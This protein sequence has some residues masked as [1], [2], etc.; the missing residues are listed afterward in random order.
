MGFITILINECHL[1]K[2]TSVIKV[3]HNIINSITKKS[4]ILKYN[5]KTNMAIKLQ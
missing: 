1:F 2:K 4:N 3:L 5:K